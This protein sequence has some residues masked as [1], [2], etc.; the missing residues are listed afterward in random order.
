M[1]LTKIQLIVTDMD[2]TLLNPQ[3][4]LST[5]FFEQFKNYKH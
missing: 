5:V 4:K 1:D 3:E 2:G